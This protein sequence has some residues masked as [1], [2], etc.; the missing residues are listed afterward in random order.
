VHSL[1]LER[2][3]MHWIGKIKQLKNTNHL[4]KKAAVS[5]LIQP[6]LK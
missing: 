4:Y 5:L 1:L 6:L 2:E 3:L